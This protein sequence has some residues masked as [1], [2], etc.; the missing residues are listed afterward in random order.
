MIGLFFGLFSLEA[1]GWKPFFYGLLP[2]A[3]GLPV[4]QQ[5]QMKTRI[6]DGN[7]PNFSIS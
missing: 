1:S 6:R 7:L 5:D 4:L 3:Y 2:V